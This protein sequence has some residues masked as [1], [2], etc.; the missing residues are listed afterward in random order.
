MSCHCEIDCDDVRGVCY[1]KVAQE[2][3]ARFWSVVWHINNEWE[4][5]EKAK[6][7]DFSFLVINGFS[8]EDIEEI[9]IK[10]STWDDE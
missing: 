7:N 8:K 3:P 6:N 9:K 2:C 1:W 4:L 10:F 5:Y